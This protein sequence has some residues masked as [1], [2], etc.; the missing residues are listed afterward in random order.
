ME[1]KGS[2]THRLTLIW[3]KL[4][5][6]QKISIAAVVGFLFLFWYRDAPS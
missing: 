4:T 1:A 5:T 6:N 3:N 2:V